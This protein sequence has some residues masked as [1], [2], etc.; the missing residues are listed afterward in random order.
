MSDLLAEEKKQEI[1]TAT[2]KAGIV[3]IDDDL[4]FSLMLKEY[5]LEHAELNADSYTSGEDFLKEYSSKDD[6]KII[7][8]YDLGKG[9]NGLEVLQKIKSIHPVSIVIIVSSQDDLEKAIE[10]I[11]K[12]ATDYF[13]KSNKT[14]F[15]NI[16]CS[17]MKIFE[18]ERNKLN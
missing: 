18:M 12:G 13:L 16:H 3:I 11:R 4:S 17:L 10:T 8:D 1:K 9:L 2:A 14:V 15:A 5:L 6:R 7:L